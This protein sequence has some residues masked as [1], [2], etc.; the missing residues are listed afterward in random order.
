MEVYVDEVPEE[1]DGIKIIDSH[2]KER[3]NITIGIIKRGDNYI[4]ANKDTVIKKGDMLTLF[5]PYKNIKVLFKNDDKEQ[6]KA[7]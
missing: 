1:L 2:L 6:S 3:Y 4:Y 5:G 7:E